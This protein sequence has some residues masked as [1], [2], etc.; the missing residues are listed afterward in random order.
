LAVGDGLTVISWGETVHR[1]LAAAQN[2]SG[3]V[4][5]LDLRT[6]IPWDKETVLASVR[7][8]GKALI[9]HEDTLTA[10]FGAEISASIAAEAF[11]DLD[12][13]IQRLATPDIPIPYNVPMMVA[14]LPSVEMITGVIDELL[15]F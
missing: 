4:T 12:A 10:G 15:S 11:T 5:V 8:T 13:P 1:C 3:Q 6:I 2:F 7:R 9:V 14:T